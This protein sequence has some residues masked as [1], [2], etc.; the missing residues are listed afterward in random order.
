MGQDRNNA[1]ISFNVQCSL[2]GG[3]VQHMVY[4]FLESRECGADGR[5]GINNILGAANEDEID[6]I[7]RVLY[8]STSQCVQRSS[9][10]QVRACWGGVIT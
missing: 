3:V 8:N 10:V 4:A 9:S 5:E 2:A 1:S 6:E 7:E